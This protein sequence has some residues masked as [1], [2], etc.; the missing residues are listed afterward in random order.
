MR[1]YV[2]AS[3]AMLCIACSGGETGLEP[4]PVTGSYTLQSVNTN[5]LPAVFYQDSLEKD[6]FV[7]G[8]VMLSSNSNWNGTLTLR[9]TDLTTSEVFGFTAPIGGTFSITSNSITLSDAFNG[10]TFTGTVN[11]G[12]LSIGTNGIVGSTTALVFQK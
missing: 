8:S 12:M 5:K 10:L 11:G 3:L 9:I 4:D 6:E 7:S 1:R 2:L